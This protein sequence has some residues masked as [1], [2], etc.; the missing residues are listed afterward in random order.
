MKYIIGI[1][2]L[3]VIISIHFSI[4]YNDF[5]YTL[6]PSIVIVSLLIFRFVF[7]GSL[8]LSG[9]GKIKFVKFSS[10][11]LLKSAPALLMVAIVGLVLFFGKSKLVNQILPTIQKPTQSV[12]CPGE[13]EE[14][15]LARKC[16]VPVVRSDKGHGSG[17]VVRPGFLVTN[18]H[19][20]EDSDSFTVRTGDTNREA[21]LWNYS[22]SYDLAILKVPTNID[23]CNWYD[24]SRVQDIENLYA[25]GWPLNPDGESTLSRGVF[26]RVVNFDGINYVQTDTS[27]NPG[28]SGGPLI[29][30]CG[31]VGINTSK[32]SQEGVQGLGFALTSEGA[33][34]VIEQLIKEGSVNTLTPHSEKYAQKQQGGSNSGGGWG[35]GYVAPP[36]TVDINSVISYRGHIAGVKDSWERARG[37]YPPDLMNKML[38]SFTRQLLFCDTLIDRLQKNGGRAFQDDLFMWDSI[39]KMSNETA[40]I[41][42]QLNSGQY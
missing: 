9:L 23:S 14:I 38:D 26:S 13:Q 22:H 30:K 15:V 39:I 18:K 7:S 28:N 31:V 4:Q 24:S 37:R 21:T 41:A 17:F 40:A 19:V 10:R 27:I 33:R 3:L 11:L 32:I 8:H 36:P 35:S 2:L 34:P 20:I 25:I 12:S 6:V 16:T 29:N 42:Q 1:L 5:F